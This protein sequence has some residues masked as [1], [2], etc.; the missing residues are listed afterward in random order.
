MHQAS[1]GRANLTNPFEERVQVQ[2]GLLQLVP[3]GHRCFQCQVLLHLQRHPGARF[4]R[5]YNP[6]HWLENLTPQVN[7]SM[8]TTAVHL[9]FRESCISDQDSAKF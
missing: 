1:Q 4:F 9:H 5:Q 2:V 6:P 3:Q 8:V 7:S